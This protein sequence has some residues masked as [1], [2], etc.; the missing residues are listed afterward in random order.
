MNNS[1]VYRMSSSANRTEH[2]LLLCPVGIRV[3]CDC[4]A[5]KAGVMARQQEYDVVRST[6]RPIVP[7]LHSTEGAFYRRRGEPPKRIVD[8]IDGEL[9]LPAHP[10]HH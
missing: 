2:G 10:P 6:E 8:F 7:K 4:S 3:N 1:L 9:H 5:M